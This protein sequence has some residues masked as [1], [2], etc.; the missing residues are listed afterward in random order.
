MT[1]ALETSNQEFSEFYCCAEWHIAQFERASGAAALIYPW[2]LR[3][4]GE[5]RKFRASVA[6][7]AQFFKVNLRTAQRA[8]ENLKRLG[9]FVLLESGQDNYEPSVY[10]VLTHQ[11]WSAS[12]AGKCTEKYDNG[13]AEQEDPLGPKL[14]NLSG[15]KIKFKPFQILTYRKTGIDENLIA[16]LFEDWYPQHRDQHNGKRWRNAVGYEFGQHLKTVAGFG[17]APELL[18]RVM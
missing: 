16:E 13:W 6:Q 9:L 8:V 4:S 12:N 1:R 18:E 5:T 14:F 3:V 17:V 15:G 11:E 10:Q 2:A 7:A